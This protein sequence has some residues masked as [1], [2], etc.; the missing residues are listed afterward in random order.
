VELF[1][2]ERFA[3]PA[4][5][6]DLF[7]HALD[8]DGFRWLARPS[9]PHALLV[10][11]RLVVEERALSAKR[12]ARLARIL[13]EDPLAWEKAHEMSSAWGMTRALR[14]LH[15]AAGGR[16]LPLSTRI[17][18]AARTAR[19]VRRRG[20]L[21]ALS[22]IDG[23]GK[24]SQAQWVADSLA[25]LGVD[26]EVV[27]NDLL[28]NRAITLMA[29]A[30]KALLGL[31]GHRSNGM[32]LY[33]ETVPGAD[34]PRASVVRS[35]WSTLVTI[36][37]A[38]EQRVVAT[39]SLAHGKVL[40]FD[41]SPLDLAVRM[42]VNYRSNVAMQRRLVALMAPRPHLAFLLDIPPEVSLARKQDI[43]SRDQL[44]EQASL[45]RALAPRFHVIPLD[46]QRPA[47]QIAAQIAREAWLALP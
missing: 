14:L 6:D 29:A 16:A 18:R 34:A 28:G 19:H 20:L 35:V 27:W 3:P 42:Q 8:L 21:V 31:A 12:R 17:K 26:T 1:A 15:R 40:V 7:D 47:P 36:A 24:S 33:E 30:P 43:W 5:V 2:A 23:A 41:R 22:G 46:G 32:A 9:P 25:A 37:N 10:L 39:R 13:A 4:A 38:L 11:A 44:C 45:Y